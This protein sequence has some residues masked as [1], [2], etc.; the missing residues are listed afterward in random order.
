MESKYGELGGAG[1]GAVTV[2]VG[3][4]G[5][6]VG[7]VAAVETTVGVAGLGAAGVDVASSSCT[8]RGATHSARSPGEDPRSLTLSTK[9]ICCPARALK[10]RSRSK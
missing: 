9:R 3:C 1:V 5:A 2:G 6:I 8:T 10:S 4:A 7:F